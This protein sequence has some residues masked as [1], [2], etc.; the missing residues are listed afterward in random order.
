M[1][2]PH[3]KAMSFNARWGSPCGRPFDAGAFLAKHPQ[4][5][6]MK[7][8]LKSRPSQPWV[9]FKAGERKWAA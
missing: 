9:T 6:W 4:F 2:R 8:I 3:S 7:E 1:I 5:E